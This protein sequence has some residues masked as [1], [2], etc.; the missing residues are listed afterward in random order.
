MAAELSQ[1]DVNR[2]AEAVVEKAA[3]DVGVRDIM[4]GSV[5]GKGA[6]P[7]YGRET[8]AKNPALVVSLPPKGPTLQRTECVPRKELSA[9]SLT[10]RKGN[11]ALR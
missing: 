9:P 10:G 6:I 3:E 8:H 11:G 1:E 4:I 5:I 2:I 7:L